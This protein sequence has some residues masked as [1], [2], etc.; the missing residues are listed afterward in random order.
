M[1]T[2]HVLANRLLDIA[3]TGDR[4]AYANAL[5]DIW[6]QYPE[7]TASAAM[8]QAQR[9]WVVEQRFHRIWSWRSE[10]RRGWRPD[11]EDTSSA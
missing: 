11:Q 3:E 5:R 6:K 4:V 8:A 10:W 1:R 9:A 2:E 7:P